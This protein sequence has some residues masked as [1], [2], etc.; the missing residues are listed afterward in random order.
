M[1]RTLL[2]AGALTMSMAAGSASADDTELHKPWSELLEAYVS[3]HSDGV[4][5]FDYGALKDNQAD[6]AKLKE[7][8]PT[9]RAMSKNLN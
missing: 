5:R 1:L 2:T 8:M 4:N 7:R 9:L 6:T 3:E